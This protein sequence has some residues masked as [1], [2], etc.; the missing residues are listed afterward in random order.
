MVY[1]PFYSEMCRYYWDTGS[2]RDS[3][4]V[5]TIKYVFRTIITII[6][7]WFRRMIQIGVMFSENVCWLHFC[8]GEVIS[9]KWCFRLMSPESWGLSVYLLMRDPNMRLTV[10]N[11]P[12]GNPWLV[13]DYPGFYL[14]CDLLNLFC[15]LLVSSQGYFSF[16][17]AIVHQLRFGQGSAGLGLSIWGLRGFGGLWLY[18]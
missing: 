7:L 15:C 9:V 13:M 11:I 14:D 12:K 8:S 16:L 10:G 4:Q 6:C 17:S 3:F 2:F 18:V 5:K 1:P